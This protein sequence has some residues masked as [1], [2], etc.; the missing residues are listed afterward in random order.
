M[1][2]CEYREGG[3]KLRVRGIREFLLVI[4]VVGGDVW[5]GESP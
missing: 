4:L 2:K 1:R 3:E 5:E